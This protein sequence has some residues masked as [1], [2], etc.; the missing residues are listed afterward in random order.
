MV[1]VYS[2][3]NGDLYGM[4]FDCIFNGNENDVLDHCF[5]KVKY[6]WKISASEAKVE[7]IEWNS[8]L[9]FC[10]IF[11]IKKKIFNFKK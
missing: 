9:N 5:A 2:H 4:L 10:D 7:F 3:K 11:K 8:H 6:F 1:A